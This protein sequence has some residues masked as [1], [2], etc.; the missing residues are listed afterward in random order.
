MP[1]EQRC[2]YCRGKIVSL[3]IGQH[4]YVYCE[5]CGDRTSPFDIPKDVIMKVFKKPETQPIIID[6]KQP[7]KFKSQ[8]QAI[9]LN[10][11]RLLGAGV[12]ILQTKIK[13]KTQM[14]D[15]KMVK[16]EVIKNRS[17]FLV[18]VLGQKVCKDN[19]DLFE[20]FKDNKPVKLTVE[21]VEVPVE[22]IA[23]EPEKT[24]ED[25]AA[26]EETETAEEIKEE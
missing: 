19:P 18:N 6:V 9:Y 26:D 7:S 8:L 15:K 16:V 23:A 14:R 20:H 22:E 11:K 21:T 17:W 10:G 2:K 4:I 13:Q 5:K 25:F 12:K 1:N 24:V 3:H